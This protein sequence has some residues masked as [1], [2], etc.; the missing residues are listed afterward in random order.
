MHLVLWWNGVSRAL[1]NTYPMPFV[2]V[3]LYKFDVD[4]V[5]EKREPPPSA[6]AV[7]AGVNPG[8]EPAICLNFRFVLPVEVFR[9]RYFAWANV[10]D[11]G[12][13]AGF[14]REGLLI[15]SYKPR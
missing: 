7:V 8:E 4:R 11:A 10:D 14:E 15:N 13:D 2:E 1:K 9:Q 12:V 3:K 6:N 5:E